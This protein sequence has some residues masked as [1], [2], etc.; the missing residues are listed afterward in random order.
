MPPEDPETIAA[1]A[2]FLAVKAAWP[3]VTWR[4]TETTARDQRGLITPLGSPDD[5]DLASALRLE[6][7]RL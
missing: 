5:H 6:R 2:F 4:I 7:D 3:G 1:R